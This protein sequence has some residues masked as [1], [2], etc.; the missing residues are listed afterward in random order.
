[1]TPQFKAGG[2][3]YQRQAS[4]R[5]NAFEEMRKPPKNEMQ[6]ESADRVSSIGQRDGT[7]VSCF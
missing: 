4:G 5:R 6:P 3:L 2:A 7:P 1:M